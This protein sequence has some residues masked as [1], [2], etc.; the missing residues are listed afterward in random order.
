MN[1]VGREGRG[2]SVWLG[3]FLFALLAHFI[4]LCER[5]GDGE[6]ARR[7]GAYRTALGAALN[8][9][10][11]DGAWYRRAYYDDGTPLGSAQNTECRI[12]AIAQAWALISGAA[13][14]ERAASALAAVDAQLVDRAAGLIRLLTPPF[15]RGAHDPGYIKGYVPGIRENG[16]QYTHGAMW[17]VGALV[18]QN[19]RE[20]AAAYLEML[21]PVSHTSS[22]ERLAVYQVEPYV[23]V[24]DIYGVAPH[25]G[26]GG[27]TWYTGSAGWMYRV[28][29][30][31]VLGVRIEAGTALVVAPCIPDEWP[32]FRVRLRLADGRTEYEIAVDNPHRT[33]VAVV[34]ATADGQPV[35]VAAGAAHVPLLQDGARHTVQVVLGQRG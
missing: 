27:W 18:A 24:A 21:S 31:S 19:R 28:A 12:D 5:R 29:F 34:A 7:Y 26:R 2:E 6:R 13:P 10:G 8:E 1:R 15:D 22:A 11:W 30:E 25:L 23:V 35:R 3:F 33:A 9:G 14:A 20:S 32:G 4:A 17:V 16:G